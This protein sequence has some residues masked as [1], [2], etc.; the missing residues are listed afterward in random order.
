MKR[1]GTV[2]EAIVIISVVSRD[3]VNMSYVMCQLLIV[4]M[5]C[6]P[7]SHNMVECSWGC[8]RPS[9][10][11]NVLQCDPI[12]LENVLQCII[13]I[14]MIDTLKLIELRAIHDIIIELKII[15]DV[16]GGESA[17]EYES[18]SCRRARGDRERSVEVLGGKGPL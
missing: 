10:V 5:V 4:F 15:V 7:L 13:E 6:P 3:T 17:V 2:Y 18:G 12:N 14:M 9:T 8:M 1:S 16:V 11:V